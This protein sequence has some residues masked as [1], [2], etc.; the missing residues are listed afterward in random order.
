MQL[1]AESVC[2]IGLHAGVEITVLALWPG[3]ED[4]STTLFEVEGARHGL[5]LTSEGL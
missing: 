5:S 2:A 3:P 1:A 4:P